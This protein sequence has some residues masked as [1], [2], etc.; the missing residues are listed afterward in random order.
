MGD[1]RQHYEG[2]GAPLVIERDVTDPVTA[3]RSQRARMHAWLGELPDADWSGATRCEGWD[4]TELV[5]HLASV[6]QF[7]AFSLSQGAAGAPTTLL[8]GFDPARTPGEAAA[9][10]GDLSPDQ[11]RALLRTF[12]DALEPVFAE[13][14]ERGWMDLAESP[15]GHV[16]AHLSL[17][18]MLFDSWV[19][20]YDLMLPRGEQPV[21]DPFEA[22]TVASYVLGGVSN[23]AGHD[24]SI[25]AHLTDIDVEIGV[26]ALDGTYLVTIGSS[27]MG[28]AV[29]E[30]ASV[31]I[32][33]RAT[34][35]LG[36]AIEADPR[37]LAVFD[38]GVRQIAS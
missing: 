11:A 4:V 2:T 38:E 9:M 7:L 8:Q 26:H 31:D 6:S 33:D 16:P 29:V 21:L 22:C 23:L 24:T 32:V 30:G 13:Q 3:W 28:A 19:H 12:D 14:G 10:L 5:R 18:H 15:L 37:V 27:P 36:G 20:E 35:R 34:G 1:I 17:D 25:S